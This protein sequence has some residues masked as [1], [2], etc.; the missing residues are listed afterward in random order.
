MTSRRRLSGVRP[1]E[2]GVALTAVVSG[3]SAECEAVQ[4]LVGGATWREA[5]QLLRRHGYRAPKPPPGRLPISAEEA[6]LVESNPGIVFERV[7]L[8]EGPY[9]PVDPLPGLGV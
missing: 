5:V 2:N 1:L 4:V 6:E 9:R 8:D 7:W 3:R